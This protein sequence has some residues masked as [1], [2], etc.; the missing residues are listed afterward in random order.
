MKKK[1]YYSF[2]RYLNFEVIIAALKHCIQLI[3]SVC[4]LDGEYV[5]HKT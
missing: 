4:D 3:C 2:V 5:S 1:Q